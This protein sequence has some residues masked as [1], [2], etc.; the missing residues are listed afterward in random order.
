MRLLFQI[1][2]Q[3]DKLND[4]NRTHYLIG[5]RAYLQNFIGLSNFW[6]LDE[7]GNLIKRFDDLLLDMVINLTSNYLSL[8]EGRI[9]EGAM[10]TMEE[11][12]EK[13][14][15]FVQTEGF[16]RISMKG[17]R[18]MCISADDFYKFIVEF[19]EYAFDSIEFFYVGIQDNPNFVEWKEEVYGYLYGDDSPL[20]I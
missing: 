18:E 20:R 12:W 15:S 16:F 3:E 17:H 5:D 7:F 6:L 2:I 11:D 13:H 1:K 9:T 8:K 4:F 10:F 19:T 14:F